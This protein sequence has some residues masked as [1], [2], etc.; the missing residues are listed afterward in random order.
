MEDR[1]PLSTPALLPALV[2]GL[3]LLVGLALGGFLLARGFYAARAADRFVT[4]KGLSEREVPAD[5]ALWPIVFTN[6]GDDLGALQ[7]KV[8]QDAAA[9]RE[10]LARFGFAEGDTALS[11]PRVTDHLAASYG[12][13]QPAERYQLESTLTLRSGEIDRVREAIQRSGDLVRAGV[14][15]I[16]SY[17]VSTQYL[18]T[19]LETI[20][21][22]MIAE[23]T[24]DARRAA[25]EFARDSGARLGGIRRAQ[26]GYFSIED[27]DAFTPE[28]KTVRVVTTVEYFLDE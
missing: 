21:P 17:E 1:R 4:V 2:L 12:G 23:A 24:R 9:I 8:E 26:Q 3:C 25:D 5:L 28:A 19:G 15:L 6:T 18:F 22:E 14:T 27:R 10:Y 11:A 16:R 20:K 7:T 13:Q